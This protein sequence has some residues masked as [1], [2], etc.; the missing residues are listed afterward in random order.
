MHLTVPPGFRKT[1]PGI[2]LH[3][4]EPPAEDIG[5]REGY[6]VTLPMRSILDA[7]A[8]MEIDQLAGV[9]EDALERGLL[10]KRALLDRAETF[11]PATSLAVERAPMKEAG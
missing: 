8:L 6:S 3:K 11:G 5:Q 1:A 10:T 4:G 7:A 2:I 9:I